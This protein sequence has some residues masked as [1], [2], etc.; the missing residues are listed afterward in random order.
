M[1][2]PLQCFLHKLHKVKSYFVSFHYHSLNHAVT[3]HSYV[4]KTWT[5]AITN[6]N[7]REEQW[8]I[9]SGWLWESYFLNKICVWSWAIQAV[10]SD[11][12]LWFGWDFNEVG[13][14]SNT[15]WLLCS[16]HAIS[17]S[18]RL[19]RSDALLITKFCPKSSFRV[20]RSHE[21][22]YLFIPDNNQQ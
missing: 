21:P 11:S 14:G 9:L 5:I 12:Y 13:K 20:T 10:L 19:P 22:H 16:H 4:E 3:E 7:Y 18:G 8:L 2:P 15:I 1:L 6:Q 17:I